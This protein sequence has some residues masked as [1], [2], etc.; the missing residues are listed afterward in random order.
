MQALPTID[1]TNA[2]P[3]SRAQFLSWEHDMSTSSNN[4]AQLAL[5]Q[6]SKRL[7]DVF[8]GKI[9]LSNVTQKNDANLK[10][11]FLTRAFAA[12]YLLDAAGISPDEAAH[13]VCDDGA[14][15]GI[16]AV[17]VDRRSSKIYFGQSKWKSNTDG[18]VKL[19]EFTRFRDGI[20][21]VLEGDWSDTNKALHRFRSDIEAA[22]TTID[23]EVIAFFA[24]TSTENIAENIEEKIQK[25]VAE[26]NK[27][28]PTFFRF[29][30]FR[31]P[32]AARAARFAARPATIDTQ[33]M[34]AN[35]GLIHSP[36][37]AIYGH[38][39]AADLDKLFAE[40]GNRLFAENYRFGIEKSGVNDGIISTATK[41]PESFWY[42][43]NGITAICDDFTKIAIGGNDTGSGVFDA[44]KVSIINGAQTVTSLVK[45][46]LAGASLDSVRVHMRIISLQNTPDDF[47]DNVTNANNTQNDLNPVDF[48]AADSNQDRLRQEL[49]KLGRIYV[50]RRGETVPRSL[51][52]GFDIRFATV[53]LACGS[54]DLKLATQAKRYISGLWE[55]TKK[56]P[57]TT[58]FHAKTTGAY[59]LKCVDVLRRVDVILQKHV[60]AKEKK[61]KLIAV[62]GNRFIA[63]CVFEM[64]RKLAL[65]GSEAEFVAPGGVEHQT[66]E[67][68]TRVTDY[69]MKEYSE[70][71]PGNFF[72]NQEKQTEV[73]QHIM[74]Q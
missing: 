68:T 11:N 7:Y 39:A 2:V 19:N 42:F 15:D 16:D 21:R 29:L 10:Q 24:H 56:E 34:L 66:E 54:G 14:D 64:L 51:D 28:N 8:D 47:A 59:L 25:F 61:E 18:G 1:K 71:Y 53:A 67:I 57:Y 55:N 41:L 30:E 63:F 22:L 48:V 62:H 43:N 27:Y 32:D 4:A 72:K 26:Q 20:K 31:I 44:K 37:K 5:G 69:I 46:R 52:E 36:Y 70:A 17:F 35:W 13:C 6:I 33:V 23:V 3:K 45:A 9:D 60:E 65:F 40:Y 50:Y 49:G 58:L 74:K 12:L 73:F 38:I